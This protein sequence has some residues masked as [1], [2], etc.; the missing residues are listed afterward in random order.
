MPGI[1]STNPEREMRL[2]LPASNLPL[3]APYLR[4]TR[5]PRVPLFSHY[6][7]FKNIT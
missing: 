5:F 6:V 4:P 1:D 2:S 3:S 7:K